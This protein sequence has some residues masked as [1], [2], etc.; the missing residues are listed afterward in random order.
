MHPESKINEM[1][2]KLIDAT[3]GNEIPK[4]LEEAND[5]FKTQKYSEAQSVYESL[6]AM[7]PG[8]PRL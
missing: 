6:I 3:P 2:D 7:E 1:V 5:L 4:L 8:I